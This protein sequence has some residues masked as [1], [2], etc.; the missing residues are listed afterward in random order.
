MTTT[1]EQQITHLL[2]AG[3]LVMLTDDNQLHIYSGHQH[4][5]YRKLILTPDPT[6]G[7]P[8]VGSLRLGPTNLHG[9]LSS[10][11]RDGWREY[12]VDREFRAEPDEDQERGVGA[13]GC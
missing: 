11:L 4:G 6:G 1:T 12:D 7:L 2:D 10:E 3:E 9:W 5:G 8:H 13:T